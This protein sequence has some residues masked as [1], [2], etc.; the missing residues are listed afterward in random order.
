MSNALPDRDPRFELGRSLI[1]EQQALRNQRVQ[2]APQMPLGFEAFPSTQR[3]SELQ[4]ISQQG[5]IGSKR[6]AQDL[7]GMLRDKPRFLMRL[8]PD[9]SSALKTSEEPLEGPQAEFES[10]LFGQQDP[11]PELLEPRPRPR[12]AREQEGSLDLN[13]L[14]ENRERALTQRVPTSPTARAALDMFLQAAGDP[15]E[16]PSPGDG[17]TEGNGSTLSRAPV[18][19]ERS[20]VSTASENLGETAGTTSQQLVLDQDDPE[21]SQANLRH[22]MSRQSGA[23][24]ESL[25]RAETAE[26][27]LDSARGREQQLV[28]QRGQLEMAKDSQRKNAE[29]SSRQ[30]QSDQDQV[31]RLSG[32]VKQIQ[33]SGEASLSRIQSLDSQVQQQATV[34][35][36]A[37]SDQQSGQQNLSSLQSQVQQLQQQQ[38]PAP[39]APPGNSTKSPTQGERQAEQQAAFEQ[40]QQALSSAQQQLSQAQQQVE[41]A[42]TR[43]EAAQEAMEQAQ[44][45]ADRERQSLEQKRAQLDQSVSQRD[46]AQQRTQANRAH[47]QQDSDRVQE[48]TTQGRDLN[49][50]FDDVA[51]AKERAQHSL[52]RNRANAEAARRNMNQL[53]S[54]GAEGDGVASAPLPEQASE[55]RSSPPPVVVS[56]GEGGF[57]TL[58]ATETRSDRREARRDNGPQ[59]L[60]QGNRRIVQLEGLGQGVNSTLADGGGNSGKRRSRLDSEGDLGSASLKAAEEASRPGSA[61]EL[62]SSSAGLERSG[63][64]RGNG[65]GPPAHSNAGG[66][67]KGR[68]KG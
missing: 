68:G 45:S 62:S 57:E 54:L 25:R 2:Q 40:G 27:S 63:P 39:K 61:P 52:D 51:E 50:Q 10:V 13:L 12:P 28:Q 30:V 32:R 18:E 41:E 58:G 21:T 17:P 67:G 15:G 3:F 26:A 37:A 59:V 34:R 49:S 29:E 33:N 9:P 31:E 65:N 48:L 36:Q 38:A 35:D 14:P 43:Q 66:N 6:L 64:G 16:A 47:L 42:R 8:A 20:P 56:Q 60:E 4:E 1:A 55:D 19:F 46:Q 24:Q 44:Q 5:L 23:E 22:E 11:P 53:K 7:E